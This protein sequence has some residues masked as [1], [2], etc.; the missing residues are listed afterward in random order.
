MLHYQQ[1]LSLSI[2]CLHQTRV[3]ATACQTETVGRL[4]QFSR[5]E[6]SSTQLQVSQ[7][8]GY[9][10]GNWGNELEVVRGS[11][12]HGCGIVLST[13][14]PHINSCGTILGRSSIEVGNTHWKVKIAAVHREIQ[15]H[16][17]KQFHEAGMWCD[18][19]HIQIQ[20][21]LT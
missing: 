14:T 21:L 20:Y 1:T 17:R 12:V 6:E 15:T 19:M 13:P 9:Q 16:L 2:R 8:I 18:M 7:Q 3:G 5:L 11:S 4:G 10:V